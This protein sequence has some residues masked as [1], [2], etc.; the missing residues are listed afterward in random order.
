MIDLNL[1]LLAYL[2]LFFLRSALQVFLSRLNSA[3]LRQYGH[4][5]PSVFEGKLNGDTLKK[6]SAYTLESSRFEL[7][8]TGIHQGAFLLILLSGVLPWLDLTIR[9]GEWGTIGSGLI[10]FATLGIL[11]NMMDIPF[12]LYGTFVIEARHGF[13]TKTARIWLMD[14]AKSLVLSFLLG[15]VVLILVLALILHGGPYWWL[16]AWIAVGLFELLLLWLYPLILAPLFNKFEPIAD[17][18]LVQRIEALMTRVGLKSKG[19]FRMDA[20]KRSKHT[21]AYFTGLGKSK[22]IVLF[23]TLLSSHT[24]EE[25]LAV[26]A[27]EMG[28]WKKKHILKQ[29]IMVELLS[30]AGFYVTARLLD[31]PLLYQTFGFQAPSPYTG[32]F[33]IGTIFGP[34]GYFLQPIGAR[35]SRRYEREADDFARKLIG[36]GDSL[37][38]ALKRLATDNLANL[39][40][41]PAYAWFYYSHPPLAERISHLKERP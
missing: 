16:W 14:L 20:S 28:H 1:L 19:V 23:D 26:L 36:T 7:I 39:N 34:L 25:T 33:L 9:Q 29:L 41:H 4:V 6:I 15:G 38:E 32:L 12:D 22:R 30:L 2:I 24:P 11:A 5:V 17:A 8:S 3:H 21:N 37:A 31:W 27:H 10:F 13:N 35:L 18:E 40:P